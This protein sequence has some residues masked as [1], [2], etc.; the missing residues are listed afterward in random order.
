MTIL[1]SFDTTSLLWTLSQAGH[2]QWIVQTGNETGG[3]SIYVEFAG[4]KNL[5]YFFRQAISWCE[6]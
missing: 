2:S 4:I 3:E 6:C 5:I 1:R